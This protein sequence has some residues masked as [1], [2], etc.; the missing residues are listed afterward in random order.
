MRQNSFCMVGLD[1]KGR[2][3]GFWSARCKTMV[4][5]IRN[6]FLNV[7]AGTECLICKS[8]WLPSIIYVIYVA[9]HSILTAFQTPKKDRPS[10]HWCLL[11]VRQQER[12]VSVKAQELLVRSTMRP[13]FG[14]S[15]CLS[16]CKVEH[17]P[18]AQW[19]VQGHFF[20]VV[21]WSF[22]HSCI[23]A[24][25]GW[26]D[27]SS[28]PAQN[29]NWCWTLLWKLL[30]NRASPRVNLEENPQRTRKYQC[31]CCCGN[32][33]KSFTSAVSSNRCGLWCGFLLHGE[34]KHTLRTSGRDST[35]WCL[36]KVEPKRW[37]TWVTTL[38]DE[39]DIQEF[40][41]M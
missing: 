38:Y 1:H 36:S 29:A 20:P 40:V 5:M 3:R 26:N 37:Q 33:N 4:E 9:S 19:H 8:L 11:R 10:L 31:W 13:A 30:Q 39:Q 23:F 41:F 34:G 18:T 2:S 28:V 7:S 6:T 32:P 17:T 15:L 16:H 12:G 14:S 35:N 24:Q 25:K 21:T 27:T 22:C